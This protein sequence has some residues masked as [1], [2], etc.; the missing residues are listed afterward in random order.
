MNNAGMAISTSI[1]VIAI[2]LSIASGYQ[3]ETQAG[4]KESTHNTQY[5]L[6]LSIGEGNR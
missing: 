6:N 4:F 3:A 1:A 5:D 2:D